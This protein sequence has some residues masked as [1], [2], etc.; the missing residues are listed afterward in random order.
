MQTLSVQNS[1]ANNIR[2]L[3]ASMVEKAKSGHPGGAMGGADFVNI[4]FSEFLVFDPADPT[5]VNRDRFFLDP[6]HMS[7]MLY[8]VLAL[9]GKYT[10][11]DLQQFR[12]W[13]SI[14]PGHPEKDVLHG[15][16]NTSGPLG[17]GHTMAVGAAITER[18][19]AARFG[20][21]M[22][23]KIY[24]Y[25]SD[26]GIQE[27]ISQGAG[28]VAGTLGLHNLI[29]F[30]DSNK[31]QLSS[32][33][34]VVSAENTAQKYEAWGWNVI[35]I[36]GN[37]PD[38]IRRAL[39]K[40]NEETQRPTIIIGE[41]IMGKGALTAEGTSF[42]NQCATHGM[43]LGESGASFENT[44]KNLGGDPQNPFTIFPETETLY[45]KRMEELTKIVA[46][47]K[48]V[49]ASWEKENPT[50]AKKFHAFF[51]NEAPAID[52]ASIAQKPDQATRAASS[53]VLA[54]LATQVENMI[55]ASADL[56][57]SDKTDGFLKKTKAFAKG[58]FSGA[59]FQAGVS[60]SSR[61]SDTG[62]CNILCIFRLYET[63]H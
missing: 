33:V 22:N 16:E 61:R 57:N 28:R 15:V 18:F 9:T 4:L 13:G 54:T 51:S 35:K 7:A 49:Q 62:L 44:I 46:E 60:G 39:Q 56:S 37:D 6:G 45:A 23:H 43:P 32:S 38:A 3:A 5:W 42:E 58:D 48:V 11:E 50:L 52:Y 41:T 63:C 8:S 34:S 17:Q 10:M 21:W 27:E 1:A 47:H 55:V 40:A 24:A 25:I 31:I 36:N 26:G 59:F 14:T 53:T 20:E 2:I 30:Y 19:L 29:L 12:Q